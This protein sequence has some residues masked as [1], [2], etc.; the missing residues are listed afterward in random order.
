MI[1]SASSALFFALFD[2]DKDQNSVLEQDQV[3]LAGLVAV[4][5]GEEFGAALLVGAGRL[6]LGGEAAEITAAP[7]PRA[8]RVTSSSA[9]A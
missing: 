7:A 1:D 3:D 4:A 2:L 5:P 9:L 8:H 6:L